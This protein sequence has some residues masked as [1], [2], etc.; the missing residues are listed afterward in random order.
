MKSQAEQEKQ[1]LDYIYSRFT[2]F[3]QENPSG[4]EV[5]LAWLRDK[6]EREKPSAPHSD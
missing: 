4:E 1:D 5:L 6:R 2:D 3:L